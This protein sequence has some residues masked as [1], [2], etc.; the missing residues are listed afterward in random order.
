MLSLSCQKAFVACYFLNLY[1]EEK[2]H[3]NL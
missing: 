1:Q 3:K 2:L